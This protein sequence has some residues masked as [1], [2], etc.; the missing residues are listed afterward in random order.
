MGDNVSER[1]IVPKIAYAKFAPGQ[2]VEH[3]FLQYRG[4]V[5]D[6]D[7]EFDDS[8]LAITN[9]EAPT[10]NLDMPWYHILVEGER[11]AAYIAED[12]LIPADTLEPAEFEHPMLAEF[13]HHQGHGVISALRNL[14]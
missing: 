4:L 2:L 1:L 10:Q 8:I 7:A 5:V 6:L 3:K 9:V 14:N 12:N 11:H 13:F